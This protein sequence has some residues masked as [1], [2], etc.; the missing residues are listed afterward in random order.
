[1]R[2]LPDSLLIMAHSRYACFVIYSSVL[3]FAGASDADVGCGL[4][5][6]LWTT[7]LSAG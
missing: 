3:H 2:Q 6:R 1:M 4:T 5:I 7:P